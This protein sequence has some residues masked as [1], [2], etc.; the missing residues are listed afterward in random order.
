MPAASASEVRG[1]TPTPRIYQIGFDESAIADV[2]PIR[3][4][5]KWPGV[6]EET[7]AVLLVEFLNESP[8]I[9]TQNFA[10]RN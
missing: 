8:Q 7:D 6:H 5:R 1:D 2:N 4:D 9:C 10:Q 3:P